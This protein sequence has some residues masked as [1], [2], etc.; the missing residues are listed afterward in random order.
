MV[1]SAVAVEL[2]APLQSLQSTVSGGM[3]FDLLLRGRRAHDI[4]ETPVSRPTA[5]TGSGARLMDEARPFVTRP[6]A[7]A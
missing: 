4:H 2:I 3:A 7:K 6:D 1:S 5:T